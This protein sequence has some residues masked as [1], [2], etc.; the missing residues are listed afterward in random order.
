MR[1][2]SATIEHTVRLDEATLTRNIRASNLPSISSSVSAHMPI[3]ISLHL[4]ASPYFLFSTPISSS[5][6]TERPSN[7]STLFPRLSSTTNPT[8]T[9]CEIHLFHTLH[10]LIFHLNDNVQHHEQFLSLNLI[11]LF[12]NLFLPHV[13]S[14]FHK[15]EKEFASNVDLV[16]V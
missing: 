8:L 12:L 15:N 9:T 2:C 1:A 3:P 6:C 7:Q 5:I 16:A 11:E 13:E 4:P 14:Y 10:H